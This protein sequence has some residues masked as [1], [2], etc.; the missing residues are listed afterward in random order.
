MSVAEPR[1]RLHALRLELVKMQATVRERGLRVAV[2]VEG[3][4]AAGK[5]G[6]IRTVTRHV[7]PRSFRIVALPKPT[8]EERRSWYFKRYVAHLPTAGEVVLF[9]RSWY[10]RGVVEPV[11]GFCTSAETAGFLEDAPRFEAMITRD[12]L[13]LIKI[14]LEVSKREQARRLAARREDPLKSWKV[15]SVD[16]AAQ[17]RWKAFTAARDKMLAATSCP[18][19][20]WMIVKADDKGAAREAV[21][22][23]ILRAVDY[24]GRDDRLVRPDPGILAPFAESWLQLERSR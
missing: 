13:T 10:N 21:I 15:S 7:S 16:D 17:K 12:G 19:A 4:D 24:K 22:A 5:D 6:L 8:E 2:L 3:R 23:A 20:P 14:W 18:C 11:M 1:S 9:N